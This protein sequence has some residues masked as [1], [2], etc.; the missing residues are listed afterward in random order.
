[1]ASRKRLL[2]GNKKTMIK[3]INL[4]LNFYKKKLN[5]MNKYFYISDLQPD[6]S[7][8]IKFQGGC[9]YYVYSERGLDS[10]V[11]KTKSLSHIIYL[12]VKE[13]LDADA[14]ELET[15]SGTYGETRVKLK[16]GHILSMMKKINKNFAEK[17][18]DEEKIYQNNTINK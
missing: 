10:V 3:I 6:D 17:F 5:I 9:I 13:A 8:Y 7:F 15:V 4:I 14:R 18:E 16:N 1:M 12:I 11:A 2:I